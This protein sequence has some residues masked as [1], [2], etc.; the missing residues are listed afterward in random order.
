MA[1]IIDITDKLSFENERSLVIKDQEIKL[2][3]DAPTVL[4]LM[5]AM[6]ESDGPQQV[7]TMYTMIFPEE[8]REIIDGMKLSFE[9]FKTVVMEAASLVVGGDGAA[10]EGQTH[11]TT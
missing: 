9:D 2:N 11:T 3:A 8:S 7:L 4:K 5:A 1:K 6:S 10:G